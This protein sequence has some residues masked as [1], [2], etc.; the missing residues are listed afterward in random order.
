MLHERRFRSQLQDADNRAH[1]EL[2][3]EAIKLATLRFLSRGSRTALS[4]GDSPAEVQKLRNDIQVKAMQGLK[5]ENLQALVIV[6]FTDVSHEVPC[7]D[8]IGHVVN[9]GLVM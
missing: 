3:L 7:R 9:T 5:V 2:L 8:L 6:A 1:H 4:I